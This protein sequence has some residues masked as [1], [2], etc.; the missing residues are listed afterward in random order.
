MPVPAVY[1]VRGAI[2]ARMR[3]D[4]QNIIA[5]GVDGQDRAIA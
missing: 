2:S 3:I 5:D 4:C 1:S